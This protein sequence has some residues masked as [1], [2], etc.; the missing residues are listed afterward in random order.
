M[1]ACRW[2]RSRIERP[3]LRVSREPEIP[4]PIAPANSQ[5][6]TQPRGLLAPVLVIGV[7]CAA[8]VVTGYRYGIPIVAEVA[9]D[10]VPDSVVETIGQGMFKAMDAEVF[11]ATQLPKARRDRLLDRFATLKQPHARHGSPS[12]I[13]FRHSDQVGPNAMALPSGIVVVTDGLVEL[14]ETDEELI[15]V[16]AHEVGHVERR[17]G[18]RLVLQNS[19]LSLAVAWFVG[20]PGSLS[21]AAPT[22]LLEAKYSR[23]VEREADAY[24]VALLD[25]NGIDRGHFARILERLER[26][27]PQGQTGGG[28]V[29]SYLSTHPVTAERLDALR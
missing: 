1:R 6:E 23:D 27:R 4:R 25:A 26:V 13:L 5:W 28:G 24:A 18:L 15:A 10:Q 17:H 29:S 16:L 19:L 14:A 12:Q 3:P 21:A 11:T 2:K 20:D 9:A 7:V 22:V 8:L